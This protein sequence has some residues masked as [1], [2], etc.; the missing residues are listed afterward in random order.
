MMT[1]SD[2]ISA[3]PLQLLHTTYELFITH[4]DLLKLSLDETITDEQGNPSDKTP[5]DRVVHCQNILQY[6]VSGLNLDHEPARDILPIYIY[7]NKLLI[8][9][10]VKVLRTNEKETVKNLITDITRIVQNLYA[11]IK[12]LPDIDMPEQ[13]VYAS[14]GK[15]GE[16]QEYT[17]DN[18]NGSDFKA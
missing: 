17:P 18:N 8:Q 16:L 4:L 6:L 14:Y 7:I 2:I 13:N 5:H 1:Q 3:T 15:G 11:G 10:Q 12:E 9:C